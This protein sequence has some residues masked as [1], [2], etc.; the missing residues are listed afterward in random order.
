MFVFVLHF[1]MVGG[2]GSIAWCVLGFGTAQPKTPPTP[3]SNLVV[4]Q[5]FIFHF[6]NFFS[7]QVG[8]L[9]I[10]DGGIE[11]ATNIF[12]MVGSCFWN[13]VLTRLTLCYCKHFDVNANNKCIERLNLSFEGVHVARLSVL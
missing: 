11:F 8:R 9:C 10:A 7:T 2:F 13:F 3:P 12:E 6:L 4:P 1:Y 5:V